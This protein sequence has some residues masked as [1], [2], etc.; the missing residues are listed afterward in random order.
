MRFSQAFTLSVCRQLRTTSTVV[1]ALA[2]KTRSVW[3]GKCAAI[4]D[5]HSNN[6]RLDCVASHC[7]KCIWAQSQ[8]IRWLPLI[9]GGIKCTHH[10][11][12]TVGVRSL[13]YDSQFISAQAH[14]TPTLRMN[15]Y[16]TFFLVAMRT[17]GCQARVT[18]KQ[19]VSESVRCAKSIS[20]DS[21]FGVCVYMLRQL[22]SIITSSSSLVSQSARTLHCAIRIGR[23]WF[24]FFFDSMNFVSFK[25]QLCGHT[26]RIVLPRKLYQINSDALRSSNFVAAGFLRAK[27][28]INYDDFSLTQCVCDCVWMKRVLSSLLIVWTR[29]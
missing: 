14:Q 16:E 8:Q 1:R 29:R 17:N 4:K 10:P 27:M 23:R 25:F 20:F 6:T 3:D 21:V 9:Y 13:R 24:H 15:G 22:R 11:V 5:T 2:H 12:T 26:P 28:M 18:M 19:R 7:M